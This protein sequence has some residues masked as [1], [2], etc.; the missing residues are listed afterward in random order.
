MLNGSAT[1]SG[2][3]DKVNVGRELLHLLGPDGMSEFLSAIAGTISLSPL[4]L[5]LQTLQGSTLE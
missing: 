4:T 5:D 2:V 1:G 3:A